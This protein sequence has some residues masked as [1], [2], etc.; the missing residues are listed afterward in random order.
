MRKKISSIINLVTFEQIEFFSFIM[1]MLWIFSPLVEYTF[2]SHFHELYT[3]YFTYSIYLIGITG[4]IIYP[5]YL[6]KLKKEKALTINLFIPEI[7]LTVLL[8]ISIIAT[9]LSKNPQLSFFGNTYRKEG[10]LVYIMYIGFILLSSTIRKNKYLKYLFSSMIIICLLITFKP[11]LNNSFTNANFYSVFHNPNHYGYYLMMNTIISLFIIINS[12]NILEKI[13]YT[14]IYIFLLH[15][16]IINN[17]FGSY[18]SI[19]I[20]LFFLL[21]YSII[22]KYKLI[23]VIFVIIVFILTSI[24]VSNIDIKLNNNDDFESTKGIVS[25]NISSLNKDIKGYINNDD[26]II[27]TAGTFR[28][29]LWKEAWFYTLNHPLFG[30][31]MECLSEYYIEASNEYYRSYNDRPHNSILQ[32]SSFIGI[33]GAIIYLTFIFYIAI[34]NLK[35]MHNDNHIMIYFSSM[36]YFI[37]SLFGNSMYY[38]SPY[39]MIFLGLLIGLNRQE[40][41]Q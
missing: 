31:G 17:T 1:L 23:N 24:I 5:I 16:F 36:C 2:K 30:G 32:V 39:F 22:K 3:Y 21:I 37:S 33:P 38:T 9:I 10:L 35:T 7:L 6:I 28:G 8:I 13:I 4:F 25:K 34:S 27:N 12:K 15:I 29:K 40:K 18:L 19:I 41:R 20:S 26:K 11:L 14:L